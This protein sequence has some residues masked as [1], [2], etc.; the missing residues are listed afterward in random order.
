MDE[1]TS[2]LTEDDKERLF[3]V[4]DKLRKNNIAVVYISHRMPEIFEIADV[5]TVLRDGQ[6]IA[7]KRIQDV[8]EAEIIRMMVGRELG[9]I[10]KREKARI[11]NVVFRG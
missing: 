5:V 4:I 8:H 3:E 1:P 6:H 7:T 2:A 10:F 11:G 9:D